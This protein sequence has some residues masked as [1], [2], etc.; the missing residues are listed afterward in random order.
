MDMIL[1]Y[2]R[3]I[4]YSQLYKNEED[5]VANLISGLPTCES[6][7]WLSFL[8]HQKIT[9]D[10]NHTEFDILGCLIFQ[11]NTELQ[12]KIINF[13]GGK[14]YPTDHFFDIP[15]LLNT[16]ISLLKCHNQEHRDLTKKDKTR[17]FKAYLIACDECIV[18]EV[19]ISKDGSYSADDM[20][21]YYMP[22]EL[23]KNT[24]LGIKDPFIEFVKSKL[25]LVDFATSDKLFS[26]YIDTYI[27]EK[28]YGSVFN[29]MSNLFSLST[30]LIINKDRTNIVKIESE[31]SVSMCSFLDNFSINVPQD[32]DNIIIQEK[33]LY[34]IEENEYCFLYIKFFVDKFFHSLLFD[35]AKVIAEKGMIN[36][37]KVPAY[38][39]IKQMVGQKFTEHYLFYKVI[40]RVLADR[41]YEKKT[42]QE[43]A[44]HGDGLPDYYARK[45]QRIFLFEFKD[46]QLNRKVI[47]S[48]NY[49]TIIKYIENELV[50]SDKGRPKG[51]TQLVNAIDKHFEEIVGNGHEKGDLQ[52]Y[53]ILVYS[54]SSLDIEGINYYL[55]NRFL[56]ILKSRNI[57]TDIKVKDLVMVNINTLIMFEK[58]FADK[59]IKFDILIN[60][61]ISYKESKEQYKVVPFNKYLFQK[62]KNRG[63]FYKISNLAKEMIDDMVLKEKGNSNYDVGA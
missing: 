49:E 37:E 34:K 16:I 55:N 26:S 62:A 41:R 61:F 57:R 22:F 12:H 63:C 45:A 25:F 18:N 8:V 40:N 47:S 56:K 33:P 24:V 5:N 52:V 27:S 38:V 14:V 15:A 21:K 50:E 42:G 19:K 58:A 60:D 7:M 17:L 32:L 44:K 6:V 31:H 20:L 11:F 13:L 51:V 35:I 30:Q 4:S 59:K 10:I 23:S 28:G 46:I 48:E 53:P 9:L 36:T 3:G 43:M 39:Q 1:K 2:A 29:Y 54:D